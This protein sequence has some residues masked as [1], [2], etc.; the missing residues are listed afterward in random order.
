MLKKQRIEYHDLTNAIKTVNRVVNDTNNGMKQS[1]R[2][3]TIL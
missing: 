3:K 1:D 2:E